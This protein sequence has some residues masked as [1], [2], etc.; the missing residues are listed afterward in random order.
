MN[1]M[2]KKNYKS[3]VLEI[4]HVQTEGTI[5]ESGNYKVVLEDWEIDNDPPAPYDGDVWVNI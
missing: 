3:P 2:T 4:T 5:A 1:D